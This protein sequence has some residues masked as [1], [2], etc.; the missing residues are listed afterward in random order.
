PARARGNREVQHILA[1]AARHRVGGARGRQVS[2]DIAVTGD[3]LEAVERI[4]PQLISDLVASRITAGD[5]TLWGQD[6][7]AEAS[8]RLG[9]TEA[10]AVSRPLVDD[11][12]ALREL[13][14]SRGV[15]R[16]ILC[17]MGGSSL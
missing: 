13:L 11:I 7:E 2:F 8:I 9:W 14:R 6:A 3:A 17:G 15:D 1:R 5:S 12:E 16:I 4:V 10:V